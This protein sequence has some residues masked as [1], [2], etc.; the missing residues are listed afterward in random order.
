M[1][2]K[3]ILLSTFAL[4]SISATAQKG[5]WYLGGNAGLSSTQS[6]REAGNTTT[7]KEKVLPGHFRLKSALS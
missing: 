2:T 5:S 3:T 6:K 1:K 7:K 4:V